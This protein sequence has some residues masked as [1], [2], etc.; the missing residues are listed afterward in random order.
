MRLKEKVAIVTGSGS[1]IG[2]ATAELF[3]EQGAKLIVADLVG[4]RADETVQRIGSA[5]GEAVAIEMD[6]AKKVSVEATVSLA[7]ESYGRIDILV[8]NA[9]R[10]STDDI[11]EFDEA[12][13]DLDLSVVLKGVFLCTQAVLPTMM[14]QNSGAIV[15]IASVN[16]LSALGDLAYSAGKAGVI[17]LTKNVAVSYGQ[18]NIRVNAICPGS[19]RTPIWEP[20]LEIDPDIFERLVKWYPLGRIGEP[21]DIAYAALFLASDEAAWITGETLTVD[22]GLLAGSYRM[23]QELEAKAP[24]QTEQ[25]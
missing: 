18:H 15:N 23:S 25:D 10:S 16:G 9:A 5:G 24:E 7:L 21:E 19:V 13:W 22:G 17:N 20:Q 2:Q 14:T 12:T 6:V 4:A 3:A 11:L 8:N 1:G